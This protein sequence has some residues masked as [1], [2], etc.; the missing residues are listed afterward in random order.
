MGVKK[1]KRKENE[2]QKQKIKMKNEQ[3]KLFKSEQKSGRTETI[4][5]FLF[6]I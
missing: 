3:R 6:C 1:E 2:K 4:S 5:S